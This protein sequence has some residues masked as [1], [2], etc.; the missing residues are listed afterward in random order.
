MFDSIC[1]SNN[2]FFVDSSVFLFRLRW[3][4][5]G[6]KIKLSDAQDE[7]MIPPLVLFLLLSLCLLK[8][9][10]YMY[11]LTSTDEIFYKIVMKYLIWK[12]TS[13]FWTNITMWQ[14]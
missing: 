8:H 10:K 4:K 12:I 9:T 13:H 5:N 6:G 7:S 11:I 14:L 2:F 3:Y 1:N